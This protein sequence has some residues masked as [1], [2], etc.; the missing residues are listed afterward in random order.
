MSI[1]DCH[2]RESETG[3]LYKVNG[4]GAVVTGTFR[5]A[6]IA[7]PAAHN[8]P[9]TLVGFRDT[10]ASIASPDLRSEHE[11]FRGRYWRRVNVELVCSG[12]VC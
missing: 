10:P 9:D 5:V 11:P 2:H 4:Y 3:L 8:H 12:F 6:W 7:Q 1:I